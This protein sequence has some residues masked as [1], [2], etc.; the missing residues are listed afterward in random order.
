MFSSAPPRRSAGVPW[1]EP[2]HRA[3]GHRHRRRRRHPAAYLVPLLLLAVVGGAVTLYVR[4]QQKLDRQRTEAARYV[5]AWVAR[6]ARAMYDAL[7][8]RSRKTYTLARFRTLQ[9]NA[10]DAAT[11]RAVAVGRPS[12]LKD[13]KVTVPVTVTTRYF[14]TL[15]G[16]VR[17]PV[18]GQSG[19]QWSPALRLPGL[20]SGETPRRKTLQS[21]HQATVLTG[22]GRR[23]ADDPLLSPFAPGLQKR[24][25]DRINGRPG[26]ELRFGSRLIRRVQPRSG[27]SV[28]STLRRTVQAAAQSA[29]GN[30]LGG[31]AVIRP[32]DGSVLA[33]AGIAVS[34]PQPPGSTFKIITLSGALAAGIASPSSS[35]P[36]RTSATLSGV[37]LANASNESCGGS[38]AQ[39]FADSCNSV[40]APLGA[41]LGAQRLLAR[42]RAFGFDETPRVPAAKVSTLGGITA[43]KDAIA[44]GSAAIGQNKDQATALQMASV[45]AAIGER[46]VRAKPRVVR[47]DPVI[48]RRAVS[49]KVAAQVRDMMVGVVRSGTGTAA[50][51]PGVEVAGKTGTAELRFTGGAASDPK[52]TDAWFVAFAPARNPRVAVGVMLVGAGA[53]GTAAAPIARR[54]LTAALR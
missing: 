44:V 14:G 46:G 49:A 47:S 9:R 36:V 54:V 20:R 42:A 24:Y 8:D 4:H 21:A 15:R 30:K 50:A 17:L 19:V 48:R 53:G 40:F 16:R 43:L 2:G 18:D 37:R 28:R 26:A 25:A 32:S 12:D 13:G 23:L 22:D 11:V 27:R 34:A 1:L 7:D 45:G 52:N 6:D 31:V 3:G 5:K 51:I 39:S 33:L 41:R 38:L 35:Y 29:L 10:D